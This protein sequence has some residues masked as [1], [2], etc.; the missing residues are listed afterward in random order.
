MII[1]EESKEIQAI[2]NVTFKNH[3]IEYVSKI[4][5]KR[6]TGSV[7]KVGGLN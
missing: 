7:G 6:H 3:L 1:S 5:A 4:K 2:K